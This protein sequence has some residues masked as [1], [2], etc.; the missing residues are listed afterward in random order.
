METSDAKYSTGD[1]THFA[2]SFRNTLGEADALVLS[3]GVIRP[4]SID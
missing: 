3:D 2:T 1:S 4:I